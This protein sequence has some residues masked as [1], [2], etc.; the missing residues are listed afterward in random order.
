M[1]LQEITNS[2]P[3]CLGGYIHLQECEGGLPRPIKGFTVFRMRRS[4]LLVTNRLEA[5]T[6]LE[7]AHVGHL[8]LVRDDGWPRVAPLNF[9]FHDGRIYFHGAADGEKYGILKQGPK[10]AFSADI[11]YSMIPS[12]WFSSTLACP[13][14][15]LFKSVHIRGIAEVVA[16]V[17]EKAGALAMIMKKYQPEGKHDPIDPR[18]PAYSGHL[19][20]TAVFRIRIEEMVVKEKFGQNLSAASREELAQKLDKRGLPIDRRSAL[21]IKKTL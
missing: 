9:V 16:D 1:F 8:G 17:K 6:I 4:E 19:E 18:D 5:I 20:K 14:T 3:L 2:A 13:A 11:P 7:Q 21:E 12:Y 15:Q 10:V